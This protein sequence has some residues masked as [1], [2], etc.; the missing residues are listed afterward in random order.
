MLFYRDANG[1][2][3]PDRKFREVGLSVSMKDFHL[4]LCISQRV[5]KTLMGVHVM[6][7]L[8]LQ[9][10][11]RFCKSMIRNIWNGS[12]LEG[13]TGKQTVALPKVEIVQIGILGNFSDLK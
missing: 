6:S 3:Q 9:L 13:F 10:F 12:K 5:R 4:N 1:R 8:C 2:Q 7:G 11:I